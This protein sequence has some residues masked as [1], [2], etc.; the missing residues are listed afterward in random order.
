[1]ARTDFQRN[2]IMRAP[3]LIL[4]V[5]T[6]ALPVTASA[7]DLPAK[8]VELRAGLFARFDEA[9]D[10]LLKLAEAIPAQKYAWRP[11]AGTRSIGEVLVH[12]AQANYSRP[13]APEPNHRSSCVRTRRNR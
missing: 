7:Q 11:V 4:F 5:S 2:P 9:S 8:P 12:V 3:T 6:I 13:A 1:V 10:K